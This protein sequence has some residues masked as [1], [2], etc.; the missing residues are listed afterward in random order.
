M[1]A[2]LEYLRCDMC[3]KYLHVDIFCDHRR[4]C[5]GKDSVEITAQEAS[6]IHSLLDREERKVNAARVTADPV[7]P[8]QHASQRQQM[9]L[10]TAVANRWVTE[11]DEKLKEKLSDDKLDALFAELTS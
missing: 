7:V 10:R 5:K 9:A 2:D 11:E 6:R 8:L 3:G 4:A 1:T